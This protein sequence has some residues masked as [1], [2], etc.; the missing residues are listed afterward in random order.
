MS[1]LRFCSSAGSQSC[2]SASLIVCQ[3]TCAC[4]SGYW[5][6]IIRSIIPGFPE[7]SLFASRRLRTPFYYTAPPK[8]AGKPNCRKRSRMAAASF[9]GLGFSAATP[10]RPPQAWPRP[11]APP[12]LGSSL[13]AG[14]ALLGW[15]WARGSART[16]ARERAAPA[17]SQRLRR[18]RYRWRVA[19]GGRGT[20]SPRV[21]VRW[22]PA[23]AT[24]PCA[25]GGAGAGTPNDCSLRRGR[26]PR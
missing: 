7:S 24:A 11:R 16:R 4:L 22:A 5:A 6:S 14:R 26:T 23:T 12:A 21:L 1:H 13:R 20:L 9:T 18:R 10:P 17:K 2:S 25:C 8:K 3:A 19:V 15:G